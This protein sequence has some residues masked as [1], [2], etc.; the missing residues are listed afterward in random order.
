VT[1]QVQGF[2]L[3][4]RLSRGTVY[5][6]FGGDPGPD[7]VFLHSDIIS[8]LV[9]E[10]GKLELVIDP[11][12]TRNEPVVQYHKTNLEFLEELAECDG[13]FLWIDGEKGDTVYFLNRPPNLESA[14]LEWGKTLLNFSP[15]LSTAG[16]V[17]KV[18]VR[19]WDPIR[20]QPVFFLVPPSDS[21]SAPTT[22]SATG[23]QQ[24]AQGSGGQSRR[25]IEAPCVSS[26]KA[27]QEFAE[28]I[29]F[30]QQQALITGNGASVGEPKIRVGTI[31]ELSGIGRFNGEYRVEQVTHSISSSGGYQTSFQVKQKL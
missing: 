9:K 4:H 14:S 10:E 30:E 3:L 27:A 21:D 26:A 23:Q 18:E 6:T 15:R 20:K 28:K 5:R 24:I 19:G 16:Q 31:L 13:Y 7:D 1:L 11:A 29:L 8:K 2:D 25:V 22:L 12:L 17:K